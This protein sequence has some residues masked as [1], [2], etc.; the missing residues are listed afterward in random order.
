MTSLGHESWQV[1]STDK[2]RCPA[3]G[4]A[5]QDLIRS[6]VVWQPEVAREG[7]WERLPLVEEDRVDLARKVGTQ[8]GHL[9]AQ[10]RYDGR[11]IADDARAGAA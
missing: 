11:Q 2:C 8:D 1:S 9:F 6:V 10:H 5:C 3:S 7:R 4:T